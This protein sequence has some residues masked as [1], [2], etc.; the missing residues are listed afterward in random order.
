[1]SQIYHGGHYM[2]NAVPGHLIVGHDGNLVPQ[3]YAIKFEG[4]DTRDD[5]LNT[6]VSSRNSSSGN[7]DNLLL[8]T[9]K[10]LDKS[11]TTTDSVSWEPYNICYACNKLNLIPSEHLTLSFHWTATN[12]PTT[13]TIEAGIGLNGSISNLFGTIISFQE[14]ITSGDVKVSVEITTAVSE[15]S[16]NTLH[17]RFINANGMNFTI[18]KAKLEVGT[19]ATSWVPNIMDAASYISDALVALY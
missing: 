9:D 19:K 6:I 12:A 18:S 10:V 4:M 7:G 16:D 11:I 2:G 14:G 17:L 13:A 3:R 15:S 8:R 5:G 1:M